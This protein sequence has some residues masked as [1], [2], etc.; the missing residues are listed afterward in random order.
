MRFYFSGE[1]INPQ[2]L[3]ELGYFVD[4]FQRFYRQK[5]DRKTTRL[6]IYAKCEKSVQI[7]HYK[8]Q[9]SQ[10]RFT[11]VLVFR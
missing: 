11:E 10:K 6:N 7:V 9:I 3:D 4:D 2:L 1:R 5:L 8:A